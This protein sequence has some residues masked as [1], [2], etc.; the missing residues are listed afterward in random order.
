MFVTVVFV[1]LGQCIVWQKTSNH[2][3]VITHSPLG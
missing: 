1:T 2:W 3:E